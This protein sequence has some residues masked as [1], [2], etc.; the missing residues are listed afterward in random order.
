MENKICPKYDR[1]PIFSGEAFRRQS[2]KNVYQSLYCNAGFEKYTTCKRFII[3]ERIG[4]PVPASIMPNA[5]K[6]VEDIIAAIK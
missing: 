4:K 6:S 5:Q 2:S 3:S 1:C